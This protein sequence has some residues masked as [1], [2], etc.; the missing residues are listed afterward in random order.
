[1][2]IISSIVHILIGL[3]GYYMDRRQEG[4]LRGLGGGVPAFF[5]GESQLDFRI[6]CNQLSQLSSLL[7]YNPSIFLGSLHFSLDLSIH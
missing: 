4:S 1:M 6:Q 5:V 2:L 3:E 7:K